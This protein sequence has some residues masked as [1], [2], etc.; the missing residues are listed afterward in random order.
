MPKTTHPY[1]KNR[2]LEM[3]ELGY[4]APDIQKTFELNTPDNLFDQM[5]SLRTIQRLVKENRKTER[6]DWKITDCQN[7]EDARIVLDAVKALF[8]L[9]V[10]PSQVETIPKVSTEYADM[11]VRLKKAAPS[12]D[13]RVIAKLA[14]WLLQDYHTD[15]IN[16]LLTFEP[17]KD[18][19][20][21][22]D[23]IECLKAIYSSDWQR[24]AI[25]KRMYAVNSA[26][27]Q[28]DY[29]Q[30][31]FALALTNMPVIEEYTNPDMA[32][33]WNDVLVVF[34]LYQY[35]GFRPPFDQ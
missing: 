21:Y 28:M 3:V 22:E 6:Q 19:T 27:E 7:P 16:L 11:A 26:G 32:Q 1:F 8:Y 24:H 30:W 4:S 23:Y 15:D 2:I 13:M 20:S 14:L 35:A 18:K 33:N 9:A 12:L 31:D 17:Y 25:Y 10:F 5:P 29:I 34:S